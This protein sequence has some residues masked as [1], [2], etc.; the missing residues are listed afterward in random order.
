MHL[1]L[2]LLGTLRLPAEVAIGALQVYYSYVLRN[3]A[4][5]VRSLISCEGQA[6]ARIRV[7]FD[8]SSQDTGRVLL[9]HNTSSIEIE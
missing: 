1:E 8:E 5:D 4:R 9:P 2:K 6:C 3:G 7:W